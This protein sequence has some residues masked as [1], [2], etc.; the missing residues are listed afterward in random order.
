MRNTRIC[1]GSATGGS[2]GTLA[3]RRQGHLAL[4][5]N[6]VVIQAARKRLVTTRIFGKLTVKTDRLTR[7]SLRDLAVFSQVA[8]TRTCSIV[9]GL[10]GNE[11]DVHQSR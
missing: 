2:L 5:F 1:S 3:G 4:P 7:A 8:R 11:R 6:G 9:H 10:T